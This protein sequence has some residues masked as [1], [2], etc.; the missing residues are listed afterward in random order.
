MLGEADRQ[1]ALAGRTGGGDAA[2]IDGVAA[3][4]VQGV[5]GGEIGLGGGGD[6]AG[7]APGGTGGLAAQHHVGDRDAELEA[8]QVVGA[9]KGS[10]MAGRIGGDAVVLEAAGDIVRRCL[11]HDINTPA[12]IVRHGFARTV[13]AGD[14]LDHGRAGHSGRGGAGG[15][16]GRQSVGG[17]RREGEAV[18]CHLEVGGIRDRRH[19]DRRLGAVE[20]RVEHLGVHACG[21][22]TLRGQTIV[23]PD[24]LRR[25]Q[26]KVPLVL[27]TLAGGDDLEPGRVRPVD[28]LDDQRRLVA[29][30]H[31]VDDVAV[32]GTGCQCRA[33]QHVGLDIDH[34][35][36]PAPLDRGQSVHRALERVARRLDDQLDRII[37][38]QRRGRVDEADGLRIQP[39][40]GPDLGA[41]TRRVEIGD[42]A[43][44]DARRPRGLGQK[45]GREL[46]AADQPDADRI[47]RESPLP[48]PVGQSHLVP[49]PVVPPPLCPAVMRAHHARSGVSF[50][51]HPTI[52]A[53]SS[54]APRLAP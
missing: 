19:L 1:E 12:Q 50:A 46:A 42:A 30:G 28:Q 39:R 4:A 3:L 29:I 21:P 54:S 36:V 16:H 24:G 10:E 44:G 34:E 48:E 8:D 17:G 35:H 5:A 32:P 11:E 14:G 33:A 22:G 38:D 43:D 13:E 31:A 18:R 23:V 26:P 20:E 25:R 47:A 9:P 45:H 40:R 15:E 41:R 37:G 6:V 49:P 53:A 52:A 51:C 27:G 7:P 2:A